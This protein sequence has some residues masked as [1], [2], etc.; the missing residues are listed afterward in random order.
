VGCSS[1]NLEAVVL[2]L[3]LLLVAAVDGDDDDAGGL[4]R[5]ANPCQGPYC[6][7]KIQ[8]ATTKTEKKKKFNA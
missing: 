6:E 2:L 4:G 3:L 8:S 5:I 7:E 1:S